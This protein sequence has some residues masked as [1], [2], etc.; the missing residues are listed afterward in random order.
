MCAS[1]GTGGYSLWKARGQQFQVVERHFLEHSMS[2]P[3]TLLHEYVV[4]FLKQK[5]SSCT[6]KPVRNISKTSM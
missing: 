3:V 6:M 5:C 1:L 4:C 2:C